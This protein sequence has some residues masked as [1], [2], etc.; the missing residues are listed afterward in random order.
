M[1]IK[2]DVDRAKVRTAIKIYLSLKGSATS[3]QL[4]DFIN[5][6]DLRIR[7]EINPSVIAKDLMYCER[8]SKNFLNVA[9]YKDKTNS[10]VYYLEKRGMKNDE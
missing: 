3:R 4:S 5:D 6:L 7:A 9:S 2:T 8:E 1:A 10:L